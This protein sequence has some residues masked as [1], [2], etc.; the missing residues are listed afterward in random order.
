M[1]LTQAPTAKQL[2]ALVAR[3]NDDA[4]HHILWVDKAG[5]VH[6]TLL[7]KGLMPAGWEERNKDNIHFR[8]ESFAC[9]N[10]MVGPVAATDLQHID[11]L[12]RELLRNWD[13]GDCKLV[14]MV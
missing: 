10:R 8:L 9:G 11:R 2:Q 13:N 3:A 5:E 7:P 14:G 1:N 12:Y 4:G 6:L